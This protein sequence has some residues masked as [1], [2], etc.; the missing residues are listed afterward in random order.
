[1]V[2][3]SMSNVS[4]ADE[5]VAD[6]H[7]VKRLADRPT[8]FTKSCISPRLQ[9]LPVRD[10]FIMTKEVQSLNGV[11]RKLFLGGLKEPKVTS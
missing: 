7:R 8:L 11:A 1:M 10:C 9:T 4:G 3:L 2:L 6:L 5:N